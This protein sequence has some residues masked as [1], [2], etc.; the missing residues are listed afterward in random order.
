MQTNRTDESLMK[1]AGFPTSHPSAVESYMMLS[2]MDTE[3]M[4]D[5]LPK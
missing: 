3:R 2:L 5:D 1:G 4:G